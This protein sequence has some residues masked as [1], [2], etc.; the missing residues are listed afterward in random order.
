MR[1]TSYTKGVHGTTGEKPSYAGYARWNVMIERGVGV[2]VVKAFSFSY[3]RLD[4]YFNFFEIM[5]VFEF[6]GL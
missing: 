4:L 5:S 1:Y 2:G 6:Q 3:F